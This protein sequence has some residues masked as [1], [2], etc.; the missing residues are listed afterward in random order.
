[1]EKALHEHA[2]VVGGGIAGLLTARVLANHFKQVTVFE[3]DEAPAAPGYRKGTPQDR[4]LHVMNMR[5]EMVI[6]KYFP[7]FYDE[8]TED[9]VHFDTEEVAFFQHGTWKIPCKSK[10][11]SHFISRSFIEYHVRRRLEAFENIYFFQEYQVEQWLFDRVNN[12]VNG[13]RVKNKEGVIDEIHADLFVDASGRSSRVQ[14]FLEQSGYE[15]VEVEKIEINVAYIGQTFS[16]PQHEDF[17]SIFIFPEAPKE[18]RLGIV[19]PI[20]G[21]RVHA[22]MAGYIGDH[23]TI[24]SEGLLEFAKSL[25]RPDIYE[26][27]R[28]LTP[29]SPVSTFRFPA[30]LR[31]YYERMRNRP[32]NLIVIGDAICNFNPVYGQGMCV[33]AME[34]EILDQSLTSQPTISS[35]SHDYFK[36][37]KPVITTAWQTATGEDLRYPTVK[38]KRSLIVKFTQWYLVQ[39]FQLSSY[40]A[41]VCAAFFEVQTCI[42]KPTKLFTFYTMFKVF[43]HRLGLGKR[44]TP[45]LDRRKQKSKIEQ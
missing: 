15:Q 2:V 23:P 35:A 5:G 33:A 10:V 22:S 26:A 20:E 14:H 16:R 21:D 12:T 43:Q 1:M 37:I 6:S 17:K 19:L 25:P 36:K 9:I 45:V 13:I 39:I 27:I 18:T 7:G 34:S 29:V 41:A 38:G 28:H 40:N 8:I 31:K 11:D 3:K 44:Y 24:S 42:A 32:A 4:Q 30:N